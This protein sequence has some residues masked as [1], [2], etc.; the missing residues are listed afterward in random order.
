MLNGA[1]LLAQLAA[2][3]QSLV[4]MRLLGPATY[5]IW[6][7]LTIILTYGGFAHF[8]AEHGMGIRLPYF[9]GKGQ[10]SR[11]RAMAD[12]VF[13]AWTI[14]AILIASA[15]A[16]FAAVSTSLTPLVREGLLAIALL[17]PLNQQATFY[18]RWQGAALTDFKLSSIL[19]IIQGWASLVLV[20]PLVFWLGLHGVMI[21]SVAVAFLVY[22]TWRRGTAYRFQ[23]R[24]SIGLLWQAVRV[25]FPMTLVV[26]GGGLIQ[27]IDRIVIL[28][29]LGA[30]NLGFY[31]VT[32]LGGGL[33]YGLI[34]QAG[35]AMG[36]HI[37]IEMGRSADSPR[38]LERF[39]VT[40]TIVFAYL[41]TFAIALLIVVIPPLVALLLPKYAPGLP[42][43]LIY[44][45]GFYF[46]S[47]ILT[48][49]TILTLV[50]IARR[51]QRVVLYVQGGGIAIEAGLAFVLIKAGFGLEGAALASTAAYAF[52]G[53]GILSLAAKHVLL[54]RAAIMGFMTRVLT[55]AIVVFP[56]I[57][58]A[59]AWADTHLAGQR[60]SGIA[61]QLAVLA[62]SAGVLFPT[63][64]R[65][66]GLGAFAREI[67]HTLRRPVR[68]GR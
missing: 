10:D 58:A 51:K 67:R 4:V 48:A 41:S 36:P 15:V 64:D 62:A 31:G 56:I 21:A 53:I 28:S 27:T 52:Y 55:P 29:L 47:I 13:I 33:V 18:S 34:S 39:L 44:V 43:F 30:R 26:L 45:P 24:W 60:A 66:V 42:A 11:A 35:S 8:G 12:S 32:S 57:I 37:T 22:V 49:N 40:P 25:G 17:L 16:I 5:G 20:L 50:L 3:A 7:G 23:R 59:H 68:P 2:I 63:L 6:L 1:A 9:R 46:L 65:Q 38:S 54:S 19:S 61:L 14:S